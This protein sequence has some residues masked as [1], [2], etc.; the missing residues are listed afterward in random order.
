[1]RVRW[2][3]EGQLTTTEFAGNLAGKYKDLKGPKRV[4]DLGKGLNLL[5]EGSCS[6][7][8]FEESGEGSGTEWGGEKKG[9]GRMKMGEIAACV[10]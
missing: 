7:V 6:L 9:R 2:Q 4:S 10:G 8:Q 3:P 5:N 1:M